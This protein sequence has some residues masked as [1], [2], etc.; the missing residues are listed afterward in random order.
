MENENKTFWEKHKVVVLLL[1]ILC[2][3]TF[4]RFAFLT[5]I[6]PGIHP[7]AAANALDAWNAYL[8]HHRPVF[9]PGNNGRE[10]MFINFISYSFQLFGTGFLAYKLPGC[11]IGVLSVLG[12]FFFGWEVTRKKY[13][14]LLASFFMSISF[15]MILFE[16]TGLRAVFSV[17]CVT[18]T[19]YFFLKSLRTN[20]WYDYALAGIFLGLGLNSYISFRML[21]FVVVLGFVYKIFLN[22]KI[23]LA[24]IGKSIWAYKKFILTIIFSAIVFSPLAVYFFQ[25]R[26]AV[27]SRT[28]DVSVFSQP[29]TLKL[30]AESTVANLSLF[31]FY[32]DPNWRHNFSTL[33]AL[34]AF[35]GLLFIFGIIITIRYIFKKQFQSEETI[36]FKTNY[37]YVLTAFAFMVIPSAITYSPGGIP[38]SLRII[39]TAPSMFVLIAIA[40]FALYEKIK[41]CF[42]ENKKFLT[43]AIIIVLAYL[44]I[45]NAVLYFV[46]WGQS[47]E[48]AHEY[49]QDF[50]NLYTYINQQANQGNKVLISL[51]SI[52]V[53]YFTLTTPN[54]M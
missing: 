44:T 28:S 8:N 38:H 27:L 39:D 23:N 49:S 14:G 7:D 18:W 11:V 21:P 12:M 45:N 46:R 37:L 33:P 52:E 20:K 6:P 40:F 26:A 2:V 31:N 30:L 53:D 35:Q 34:D 25:N 36:N 54:V 9:Y 29:H 13:V 19:S 51:H 17:F 24:P 10:A 43:A 4:F 15:W 1:L 32:G 16:R 5:T 3:A 48:G 47:G 50:T 22:R 41:P 42:S